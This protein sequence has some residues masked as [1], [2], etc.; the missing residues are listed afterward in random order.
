MWVWVWERVW[1]CL[2]AICASLPVGWALGYSIEK[3]EQKT[4]A[5]ARR[6]NSKSS[7]RSSGGAW[8][9]RNG[10]THTHIQ[11]HTHSSETHR[12]RSGVKATAWASSLIWGRRNS[13]CN[14]MC[15]KRKT[16]TKTETK[17]ER[18]R[19]TKALQYSIFTQR[20]CQDT[21]NFVGR[22]AA[23]LNLPA[24]ITYGTRKVGLKSMWVRQLTC[25]EREREREKR[26][27]KF[28]VLSANC[29]LAN[30]QLG[31]VQ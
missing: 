16:N 28:S 30:F 26:D 2:S 31:L 18:E 14:W 23:L 13:D 29:K 4:Q 11:T 15:T 17:R 7:L 20:F 25:N 10:T 8:S 24:K 22:L 3:S 6:K 19:G 5:V 27:C 21:G 9:E 12:L 1:V